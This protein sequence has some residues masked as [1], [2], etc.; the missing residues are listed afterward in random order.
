[1]V[2]QFGTPVVIYVQKATRKYPS[3]QPMQ[4][5]TPLANALNI[6][7]NSNFEYNDYEQMVQEVLHSPAYE[8]KMVLVCWEYKALGDI[9]KLLGSADAPSKWKSK[10]F[11]RLWVFTYGVGAIKFEDLPQK[12][13]YDDSSK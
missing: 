1:M 9:A 2:Y 12:L 8:G 10:V 13:M 4:T 6:P 3:L 7:I 5:V 11:D